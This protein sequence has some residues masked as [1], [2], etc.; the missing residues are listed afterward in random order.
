ML[1]MLT[2]ES[3][4]LERLGEPTHQTQNL[5]TKLVDQKLNFF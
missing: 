1:N 4:T 2:L 3:C 5:P